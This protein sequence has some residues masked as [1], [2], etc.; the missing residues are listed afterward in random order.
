MVIT[1]NQ[2]MRDI[3]KAKG[4]NV[5]TV[6]EVFAGLEEIMYDYLS[7]AS[8]VEKVKI[9]LLEGLVLSSVYKDVQKSVHPETQEEIIVPERVWSN[10]RIT[11]H[12]N[13]KLNNYFKNNE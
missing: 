8:P 13:R 9:K 1:K 10:A 2:V 12:Y 5:A 3:A 6:H 4:V 11:R 7:S